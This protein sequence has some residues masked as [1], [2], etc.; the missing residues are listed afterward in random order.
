MSSGIGL[1]SKKVKFE[2]YESS[3]SS[4]VP[5]QFKKDLDITRGRIDIAERI[6]LYADNENP[7]KDTQGSGQGN[8]TQT[9]N[10]MKEET[11]ALLNVVS[12]SK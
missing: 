2:G 1:S 5:T 6:L 11:N 3:Q 4:D 7:F 12:E 9:Q 8:A 10:S